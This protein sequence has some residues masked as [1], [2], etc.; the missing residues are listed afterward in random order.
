[1]TRTL[2]IYTVYTQGSSPKSCVVLQ[3]SPIFSDLSKNESQE[4]KSKNQAGSFH[5]KS[6]RRV[7]KVEEKSLRSF[8][9]N[10][11]GNT[12]PYPSYIHA[13]MSKEVS[14]RV[15]SVPPWCILDP[16]GIRKQCLTRDEQLSSYY[17]SS[18]SYGRILPRSL[19]WR[20]MY[21]TLLHLKSPQSNRSRAPM[22]VSR[23]NTLW[24]D[25]AHGRLELADHEGKTCWCCAWSW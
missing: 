17:T 16:F 14:G 18:L 21:S 13:Y 8:L 1:M 24:F 23:E 5:E 9:K 7:R 6:K 15:A 22:T 2:A 20:A 4:E 10:G 12:E 25:R 3:S 19:A 11:V